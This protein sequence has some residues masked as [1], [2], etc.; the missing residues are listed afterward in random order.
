MISAEALTAAYVRHS[1]TV[2]NICYPYFLNPADTEDAVQDTFVRLANLKKP[3]ADENHEKAW[4][5]VTARNLCKDEL[6]RVRRKNVPLEQVEELAD[7]P[8][9]EPDETL[10]VLHQLPEQYRTALY[11]YYYEEYSTADIAELT[12]RKEA[13][14][15]MD[16]HRGRLI[17]K[18]E[19]EKQ[20]GNIL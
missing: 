13:T 12:H 19:L 5:I 18:K 11:L 1:K 17:L 9:A 7:T 10:A 15:R 14:V 2:W 8:L 3:F 20:G 16:L 4:L 6:R